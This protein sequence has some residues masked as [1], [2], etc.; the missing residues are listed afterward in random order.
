MQNTFLFIIF[1]ILIWICIFGGWTCE[2]QSNLNGVVVD[3]GEVD[4]G[5][6]GRK[7]RA[8]YF[9]PN[10]VEHVQDQHYLD[11][12]IRV[13]KFYKDE[14][15]RNG[16]GEKTFEFELDNDGNIL[17]TQ[18]NGNHPS[19]YYQYVTFER[20]M[21]ETPDK[22]KDRKYVHI[23]IIVG[24]EFI[25]GVGL[26]A[27]SSDVELY[28]LIAHEIGHAFSLYHTHR[29]ESI[30]S[31]EGLQLLKY[32]ARWLN[33]HLFFNPGKE[34]SVSSTKF[35]SVSFETA[36]K[37]TINILCNIVGDNELYQV[38]IMDRLTYVL[39][40]EYVKGNH[41]DIVFPIRGNDRQN[42]RTVTVMVMEESGAISHNITDYFIAPEEGFR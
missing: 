37:D 28:K 16:Y 26:V 40:F 42:I 36:E 12:L 35:N 25:D 7:V 38:M 27:D 10:D 30:M 4:T 3:T 20:L 2:D 8:I 14:M 19:E 15:I 22:F 41:A 5:N 9:I 6:I 31:S 33:N 34:V 1:S 29:R 32:E 13:Q 23:F 39:G 18:I 24:V 21:Q 17:T 11:S